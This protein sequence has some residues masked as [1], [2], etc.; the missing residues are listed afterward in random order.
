MAAQTPL[1]PDDIDLS[2]LATLGERTMSPFNIGP[3][4]AQI[5]DILP[6]LSNS[7]NY[8]QKW[9][10]F[11]YT[12]PYSARLKFEISN[13]AFSKNDGKVQGYVKRENED[14]S[15]E[16]FKINQKF[17]S[18]QWKAN[19][20][21]LALEFGDYRLDFHDGLFL[22]QGSFEKGSFEYEI[23]AR[24]WKPGTGSVY[25]GNTPDNFFKYSLLTYHRN[26][27]KGTFHV[28]GQDIPVTGQAYGNHYAMTQAI[29]DVFDE[30][31]D[32]RNRTDDVLVEMRYYIPSA[33]YDAQPFG[34]VLVASEGIPVFESIDVSRTSTK[35][36]LDDAHYGYEID[37]EQQIVA[38][39][40]QNQA[41]L[42]IT[43]AKP[44]AS[45][46]YADLS[47]FQRN[48]AMRF[49]KPIEYAINAN[50]IVDLLV[51]GIQAKIPFNKNYSLT[52]LR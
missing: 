7:A 3:H 26:V 33:K 40:A 25:F 39:D 11:I 48:V 8:T 46:P 30:T 41:I 28:D 20:Q 19:P 12:H 36:W 52:R 38:R 35:T 21:T 47:T 24:F 14:G 17:K 13:F 37:I 9:E 49:A 4:Q 23:P 51:E 2:A 16:E 15:I 6:V 43:N 32:F 50:W 22:L 18:G 1:A 29:Y 5:R 45:D 42:T 10:F 34:F 44:T 27:S 31:T